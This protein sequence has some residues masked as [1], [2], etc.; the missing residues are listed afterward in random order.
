MFVARVMVLSKAGLGPVIDIG[1]YGFVGTIV[2][3]AES[4][5][6]VVRTLVI[7]LSFQIIVELRQIKSMELL[8]FQHSLVELDIVR[9]TGRHKFLKNNWICLELCIFS[10][11]DRLERI[12]FQVFFHLIIHP[13]WKSL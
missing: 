9:A 11:N 7:M 13:G 4:A 12:L 1:N 8:R 5:V 3:L 2:F 6:I 10:V